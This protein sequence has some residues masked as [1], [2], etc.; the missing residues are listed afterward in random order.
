MVKTHAQSTH[1]AHKAETLQSLVE[2]VDSLPDVVVRTWVDF[3]C[4][5]VV[6]RSKRK[7]SVNC[8]PDFADKELLV[9]WVESWWNSITCLLISKS[10][11]N[12]VFLQ[13]DLVYSLPSSNSGTSGTCKKEMPLPKNSK[14]HV[15]ELF[16]NVLKQFSHVL[17]FH[18][19][20]QWVSIVDKIYTPVQCRGEEIAAM[21]FQV[22]VE[23]ICTMNSAQQIHRYTEKCKRLVISKWTKMTSYTSSRLFY[24]IWKVDPGTEKFATDANYMGMFNVFSL[25]LGWLADAR[26]WRKPEL[27]PRQ[28]PAATLL[29]H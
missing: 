16:W 19:A 6:V 18:E 8:H 9:M 29:W 10:N 5:S 7:E 22:I 1:L 17:S 28:H 27:R 15:P 14:K 2:L 23:L 26:Q 24:Q 3:K 4:R 21:T 20:S 25:N 12:H 11:Q 13:E